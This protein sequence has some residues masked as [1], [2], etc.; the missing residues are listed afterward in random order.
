M[1][2]NHGSSLQ[3]HGMIHQLLSPH[4]SFLG[5]QYILAMCVLSTSPPLFCMVWLL[6]QVAEFRHNHTTVEV[7]TPTRT[8]TPAYICVQTSSAPNPTQPIFVCGPS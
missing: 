6:D 1:P 3:A 7:S 5:R 2:V 4:F 8:P